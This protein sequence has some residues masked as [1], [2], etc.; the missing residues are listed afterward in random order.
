MILTN[1]FFMIYNIVATS[2]SEKL[3]NCIVDNASKLRLK[4]SKADGLFYWTKL[5]K[6]LEPISHLKASKFLDIDE[7]TYQ[8]FMK[9]PEKQID[10]FGN[11][12]MIEINHFVIQLVRIPRNE[13]PS[14]IKIMQ[15]AYNYSQYIG[16]QE[17]LLKKSNTFDGIETVDSIFKFISIPDIEYIDTEL[18]RLNDDIESLCQ[19]I[20]CLFN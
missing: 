20:I 12:Y 3:Y 19:K 9:L 4:N 18:M 17:I 15:L 1:Y 6:I 14:L 8:R 10:G 13:E 2:M 16:S 5:K 11:T 7:A